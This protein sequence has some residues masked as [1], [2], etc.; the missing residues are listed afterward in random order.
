MGR[1]FL[2]WLPAGQTVILLVLVIANIYL[3]LSNGDRQRQ[4]SQNQS[5]I[6]KVQQVD[7]PLYREIAQALAEYTSKGD[8]QIGYFLASQGIQVNTQP[9]PA[10]APQPAAQPTKATDAAK[11][12]AP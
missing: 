11:A 5:V 7:L 2:S 9:A 12:K 10:S 6:Q 3:N 1:R 8:T 4:I